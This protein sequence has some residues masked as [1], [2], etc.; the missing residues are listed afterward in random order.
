MWIRCR[1][2]LLFPPLFSLYNPHATVTAKP[3]IPLGTNGASLAFWVSLE[4]DLH[5][6]RKEKH[7]GWPSDYLKNLPT[8]ANP[9]LA[10]TG[11]SWHYLEWT[12]FLILLFAFS[13]LIYWNAVGFCMF[14][15]HTVIFQ[16]FPLLLHH[17]FFT[18]CVKNT[19][20]LSTVWCHCWDSFRSTSSFTN[21]ANVSL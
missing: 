3:A 5:H 12:W 10:L 16:I 7:T 9:S 20:P 4:P 1:D 13:F 11:C 14:V 2:I 19:I 18:E 15:L 17:Q 21:S 6:L 8:A